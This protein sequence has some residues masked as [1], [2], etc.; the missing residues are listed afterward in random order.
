MGDVMNKL[1]IIKKTGT[2]IAK[3]IVQQIIEQIQSGDIKKGDILPSERKL[4]EILNVSRGTI[5]NAYKELKDNQLIVS[6]MGGNHYVLGFHSGS[7][8]LNKANE[9]IDMTIEELKMLNISIVEISRLI[10]LKLLEH[11]NHSEKIKVAIIECRWDILYMFEKQ[12]AHLHNIELSLF[13]VDDV[14]K[15]PFVLK[16]VMK[17]DILLTTASHYFD[18]CKKNPVL[19]PKLVEIVTTWD[20][21]TIFSLASIAEDSHIGVL[22]SSPR[23]IDLVES[24]LKYFELKYLTFS[25]FNE[26]NKRSLEDFLKKQTVLIAEP[27]SSIF[28]NDGQNS[29][30]Q[31]F[32]NRGGKLIKFEHI[33]DDGS[34]MII[35]QTIS[36]SWE[37]K[38]GYL[39]LNKEFL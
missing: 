32:K 34:L 39:A 29:L 18:I 27:L 5:R 28:E 24:A 19:Q 13:L 15:S 9:I 23:T 35:E 2:P 20:Q 8:F 25:A 10:N 17:C 31:N 21:K 37:E 6:K 33:I 3:Q 11:E 38:T 30:A 22:Y 4:A 36:K 16:H 12:L 7:S 14:L 26:N 1:E